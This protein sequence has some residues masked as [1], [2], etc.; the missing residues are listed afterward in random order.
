MKHPWQVWSLFGICLLLVVAGMGW[1]TIKA[2]ELDVAQRI[3][4]QQL[5]LIQ[6]QRQIQRQSQ[7]FEMASNVSKAEHDA[8]MP[9]VRNTQAIKSILN[10]IR[11]IIPGILFLFSWFYV[12]VN[13]IKIQR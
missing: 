10:G 6:L 13:I 7:M 3:S 5:A 4:Q 11:D 8:R 2:M 12:I 1:L 9:A